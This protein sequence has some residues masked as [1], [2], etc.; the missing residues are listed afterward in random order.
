MNGGDCQKDPVRPGT[1]V[2]PRPVKPA[3]RGPARTSTTPPL[4]SRREELPDN[5]SNSGHNA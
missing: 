5:R 4:R 2:R 3:R 1:G